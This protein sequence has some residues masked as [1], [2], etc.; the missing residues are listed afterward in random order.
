MYVL[1]TMYYVLY[2]RID[3]ALKDIELVLAIGTLLPAL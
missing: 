3:S 1:C 2:T